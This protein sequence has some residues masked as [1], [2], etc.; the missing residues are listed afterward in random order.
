MSSSERPSLDVPRTHTSMT[1][2]ERVRIEDQDA[3]R[4]LVSIY[5]PQ[6]YRFCRVAG[7]DSADASDVVQEVFHSVSK[8]IHRFRRDRPGDSFRSW[9]LT[10]A[11]NKT[12]DHFRRQAGRARARGGSDMHL[13]VQQLPNLDWDSSQDGIRFNSAADLMRRTLLVVQSDFAEVTWK[14]FWLCTVDGLPAA[15]VAEQLDISKWSVYQ[16]KSRVLRRIRDE[17]PDLFESE[18]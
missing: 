9:L 10:I 17:L 13:M 12:R 1:L 3:W 11:K 7:L 4:N 16:A 8:A 6:V 2:I 15:S 14:A 5:G 18:L